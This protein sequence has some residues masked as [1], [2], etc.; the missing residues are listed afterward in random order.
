N[1]GILNRATNTWPVEKDILM[2]YHE[3]SPNQ[4]VSSLISD[5]EAPAILVE[6]NNRASDN[7][8][9]ILERSVAATSGFTTIATLPADASSYTDMDIGE[10][11]TYTYRM[12]TTRAD[13]TLLHGYPTRIRII[14]TVQTPFNAVPISIPGDVEVEEYDN[15]GEGL[16]YH[17]SDAANIPG[18]FR[19][20]EGVD[21]G[22]LGEGFILE[23]VNV[24]EWI[25]YTVNVAQAGRYTVQAEVASQMSNGTFSITFDGNNAVTNFSVP[26]TGDWYAFQEIS[27][28]EMIE[29]EAG[30]QQ[31]RLAITNNTPFNIDRLTFNLETVNVT[32]LDA[33]KAGFNIYPNPTNR[34]L[35]VDL[36]EDLLKGNTQLELLSVT[37][38]K[39]GTFKTNGALTTFD[40]GNYAP[41][42]YLLRLVN[43]DIHLVHRLVID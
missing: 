23:Y 14:A 43:N 18:G 34:F 2:H 41:G 7:G 12:Y 31:M 30:E 39:V 8:A 24:G 17:D 42:V 21:I 25:E 29:L 4:I 20:D 38:E 3:D 22:A 28:S 6:W 32:D 40:M 13:G 15:G 5:G 36:S 1:F 33:R 26:S 16:A 37:G 27:A 35:N 9:I 11:Q 19:L 10:G